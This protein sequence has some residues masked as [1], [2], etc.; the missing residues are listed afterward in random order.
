MPALNIPKELPLVVIPLMVV[1]SQLVMLTP[2][3]PL[4][5]DVIL[6]N[7]QL[8]EPLSEIPVPPELSTATFV[9]ARLSAPHPVC[10]PKV[11]AFTRVRFSMVTPATVGF[12]PYDG[13]L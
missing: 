8:S 1:L 9:S 2:L 5:V 3:P 4:L 7:M 10:M 11:P 13:E 6:V 12:I